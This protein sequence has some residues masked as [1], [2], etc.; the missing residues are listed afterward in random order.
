MHA[1]RRG[2]ERGA[3][4]LDWLDSRHS[5]SF[6]DYHDPKFMG[7]GPLRVINEDVVAPSA[8]FPAHP[9]RDMEI[10][11]WILAGA[12]EHKDNAGGGGVIRPGEMQH[13]SAGTGI[14]HSELNPSDSEPCHLLQIWLLPERGGLRPGYEQKRFA[15]AELAGRFR[16]VAAPGSEDGALPIRQDA[17]VLVA[18]LAGGES[19]SVALAPGRLA[20]LQVAKG[21]AAVLGEALRQGDGLAARDEAEISVTASEDAEL[22]LFDMAA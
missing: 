12:L 11:T 10:L 13:M 16:L 14:L 4:R 21:S 3:T 20:W 2:A 6:G 17:R 5:F 18:R 7:F 8:G 15:D 19:A 22:L 9:H 1:V